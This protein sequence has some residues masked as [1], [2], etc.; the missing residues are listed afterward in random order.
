MLSV[1]QSERLANI[2]NATWEQLLVRKQSG[3]G[4]L[5]LDFERCR[6]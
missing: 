1:S 2:S 6:L 4:T 5:S 3:T